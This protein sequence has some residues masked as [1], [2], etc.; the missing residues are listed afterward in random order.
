MSNSPDERRL[1]P[2][3]FPAE[4]DVR[5]NLFVAV[6]LALTAAMGFTFTVLLIR[7]G[8]LDVPLFAPGEPLPDLILSSGR[9]V[10]WAI[11]Y[12]VLGEVWTWLALPVGLTLAV[13]GLSSLL[14]RLHP[15]YVRRGR[16]LQPVIAARN[17]ELLHTI[18]E[19]THHAGLNSPPAVEIEPKLMIPYD[20]Q[21]FGFKGGYALRI[22]GL[23]PATMKKAP[24]RFRAFILHELAHITNRD[25]SRYY[26]AL[27]LWS[28][29]MLLVL[30]PLVGSGLLRLVF[31]QQTTPFPG[32]VNDWP[33]FFYEIVPRIALIL[34]QAGIIT[35]VVIAIFQS[36]TWVRE[37]YADWRTALW[38]VEAPLVEIIRSKMDGVAVKQNGWRNRIP[39]APARHPAGQ[40]R[41]A[42]LQQPRHLFIIKNDLP[43]FVG[44]LIAFLIVGV[45]QIGPHLLLA[46]RALVEV[47]YFYTMGV[48]TSWLSQLGP[49]KIIF[50]GVDQIALILPTF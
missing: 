18:V 20:G 3:A 2:F 34:V 10:R 41:I 11:F 24:A 15:R 45:L 36:L 19:L 6:A 43:F 48:L 30:F 49:A 26:F 50:N 27:A 16:S 28:A 39:L 33:Y 40:Q 38:G 13:L 9:E 5:F 35:I 31:W 29:V 17:P 44:F 37:L 23:T 12:E 8:F 7:F 4:T 42:T 25:I 46:V 47:V 1:N 14:Y 32:A 22:D 21:I